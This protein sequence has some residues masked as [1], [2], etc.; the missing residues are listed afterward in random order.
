[1][2]DT[3]SLLADAD[4]KGVLQAI[5]VP[6]KVE[7]GD[8]RVLNPYRNDGHFGSA[9]FWHDRFYD[10]AAPDHDGENLLNFTKNV[11]GSDFK[12]A[13]ATVAAAS[14]LDIENYEL[15]FDKEAYKKEKQ[16]EKV[17]LSAKKIAAVLGLDGKAE[18]KPGYQGTVWMDKD[19]VA[20]LDGSCRRE[21]EDI[22][23][24]AKGLCRVME[25][26]AFDMRR[27]PQDY[28][29]PA[30][31]ECYKAYLEKVAEGREPDTTYC[32]VYRP[33]PELSLV[34]L[35]IDDPE[36]YRSFVNYRKKCELQKTEEQK[37]EILMSDRDDKDYLYQMLL[38]H[39]KDVKSIRV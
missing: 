13:C 36:G 24:K 30:F 34:T 18:R 25:V 8:I 16:R 39:E 11:T 27:S 33:M 7:H 14:G 9:H 38:K 15:P 12:T 2:I 19:I 10:F 17:R 35:A 31:S 26:S 23:Q 20:V 32:V 28:R 3:K 6:Y 21:A 4:I 29:H 22:A 1:M 37:K 5:G